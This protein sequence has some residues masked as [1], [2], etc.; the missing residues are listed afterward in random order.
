MTFEDVIDAIPHDKL[1]LTGRE[2]NLIDIPP[3]RPEIAVWAGVGPSE[4]AH[5]VLR[6]GPLWGQPH[7][8]V[9]LLPSEA[10]RLAKTL[11]DMARVIDELSELHAE[12]GDDVA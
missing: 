8:F 2:E 3:H 1:D 12:G 7:R 10:R 11:T 5:V 6:V 9:D 4:P